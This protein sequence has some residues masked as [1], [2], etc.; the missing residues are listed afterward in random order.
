MHLL[1]TTIMATRQCAATR[2]LRAFMRFSIWYERK[3]ASGGARCC[4][5]ANPTFRNERPVPWDAHLSHKMAY[6]LPCN[7]PNRQT[8]CLMW[9][10]R[11]NYLLFDAGVVWHFFCHF[12]PGSKTSWL[13][14]LITLAYHSDVYFLIIFTMVS[15]WR[16]K[17]CTR[18]SL[19]TETLILRI[20]CIPYL[21]VNL[22]RQS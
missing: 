10:F 16:T 21:Q 22:K 2:A 8:L 15:L 3:S 12:V 13:A 5:T 7:Y 14:L 1:K 17:P 9:L 19:L 20:W 6:F 18:N 11:W 4:R